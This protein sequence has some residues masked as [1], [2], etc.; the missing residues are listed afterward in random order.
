MLAKLREQTIG[1]LFVF[2]SL[3]TSYLT[4]KLSFCSKHHSYNVY[5]PGKYI[6]QWGDPV[7]TLTQ[8]PRCP[9]L[10]LDASGKGSDT[11]DPA[12]LVA[13]ISHL[14][15]VTV[16]FNFYLRKNTQAGGTRSMTL[17][18]L[19]TR[20]GVRDI[21]CDYCPDL[22]KIKENKT[23]QKKDGWGDTTIAD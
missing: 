2:D 22:G 9:S 11:G 1:L 18:K 7:V 17:R 5:L 4:V 6:L 23:K 20:I 15:C 21:L 19:A 10:A 12:F 14:W 8:G 3:L 13:T 16:R